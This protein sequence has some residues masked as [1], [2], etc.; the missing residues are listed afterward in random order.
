[1]GRWRASEESEDSR[2]LWTVLGDNDALRL[3]Y[4]RAASVKS[5]AQQLVGNAESLLAT[6]APDRSVEMTRTRRDT[7]SHTITSMTLHGG[8]QDDGDADVAGVLLAPSVEANF[9]CAWSNAA[10]MLAATRDIQR[11]VVTAGTRVTSMAQE[12]LALVHNAAQSWKQWQAADKK[13]QNL[14][15]QSQT[16]ADDIT[17]VGGDETHRK[18][19]EILI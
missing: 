19:L 4:S 18:Q 16:L 11:E 10:G 5:L 17:D 9:S 1:M 3:V 13:F 6:L 2:L 8:A 12:V 7:L 14:Q 15:L